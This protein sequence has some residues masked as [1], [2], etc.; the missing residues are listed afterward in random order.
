MGGVLVM[1]DGGIILKSGGWYPFTDYAISMNCY[2]K[3]GL[4]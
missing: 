2:Y 3:I 1:G 4:E